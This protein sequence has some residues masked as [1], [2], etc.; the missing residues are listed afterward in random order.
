VIS[1]SE[2]KFGKKT[3]SPLSPGASREHVILKVGCGRQDYATAL[4]EAMGE[5]RATAERSIVA[6]RQSKPLSLRFS[7]WPMDSTLNDFASGLDSD[8]D[9]YLENSSLV[10]QA[11]A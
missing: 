7:T 11:D 6:A 4:A 3:F 5:T 10:A 8:V 1:R 9:P 2:R